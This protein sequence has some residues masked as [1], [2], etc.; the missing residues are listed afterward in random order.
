MLPAVAGAALAIASV[1]AQLTP[2]LDVMPLPGVRVTGGYGEV[3][4]NHVHAGVDLSTGGRVGVSVLAPLAG[5]VERV[6]ASGVGYGRSLY[7]RSRDGRLLVF[8][9]LDAFAPAV[10]A[11]VDSAQRAS[12]QYEQDLWPAAARFRFAPG[13]TI[14]WSGESGSGVAHLHFEVRHGDF[15]LD[16]L[17]AGILQAADVPP[18]LE[19]LTLE[20][21]DERAWVARRCSPFTTTLRAARETLLVEGAVR[22]VV[23]SRAGL[24]G[25]RGAPAWVTSAQWQG[26]R[27]EARLDSISWA[28]EMAELDLVVDRGRI[29]GSQGFILWRPPGVSPRFLV[30]DTLAWDGTIEVRAGDPARPLV[31]RA[32]DAS[33][34]EAER[35]VW[36]R[37]P[38]A[39]EAGPA[40]ARG[41]GRAGAAV[42]WSF[43]S[44]P[45]GRL[46]VRLAGAPAGL[47][48]VRIA[49]G[50]G[51]AEEAASW[52]GAAWS[53]VLAPVRVPQGG[54]LVA[55]GRLADGSAWSARE[56]ATLWTAGEDQTLQPAEFAELVLAPASVFERG[57]I[58]ARTGRP[59][60]ARAQG[61][62]ALGPTL[63]LSPAHQPMRRPAPIAFALPAGAEP[64]G[65]DVYRRSGGGWDPLR[66]RWDAAARRLRAE[67]SS[68]G[69][70]ALL[71]DVVAPAVAIQRP[72]RAPVASAYPRW[73]LVA[74][75]VERG[76][77][78]D[79]SGSAFTIDGVRRPSEWIPSA[80]NCAGGRCTDPARART[81]CACASRIARDT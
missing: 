49:T 69:T 39:G 62:S 58:V 77:G 31:L 63:E 16:P 10:A 35:T 78:V 22:A 51:D 56:E 37:G 81:R 75:V 1:P 13:D 65:V 24:P 30:N 76:S 71:R 67:T 54:A 61:L 26:A 9:H 73:E 68:L 29:T 3:R 23:R 66:A 20:P 53:A 45:A 70:F 38:G 42:R 46:R 33:G 41:T 28:G 55:R 7:L 72:A 11:Y 50:S 14:A 57:V 5:S 2:P 36:L 44:L 52:D 74:R 4:S 60:E 17:L 27:I 40:A 8:G 32:R 15:A 19:S 80:G 18:R 12:G 59:P 47:R 43:A 21:L 6:R 25:V 34:R 64:G 79:A 48:A